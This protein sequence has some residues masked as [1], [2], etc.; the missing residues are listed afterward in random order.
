MR[1]TSFDELYTTLGALVLRA[2]GRPWWRKAGKQA[3]PKTPYA[4]VYLSEAEGLMHP[5]TENSEFV[6]PLET[7]ESFQQTPWNTSLVDVRIEFYGSRGNDTAL[8]AATRM[9]GALYLEERFWDLWEIA[10]LSGSVRTIDL[11][12]VFRED[13]EARTEVRFKL[14]ANIAVPL[15]LADANIFDINSQEVDVTHVGQ[16]DVETE[17]VVGVQGD[18]NDSSS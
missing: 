5:V 16:D 8:Q 9:R 6:F 18:E 13:V 12:E 14:G 1:Q 11:S 4:L 3:R 17:F 7:G 10:S 2:T 15:P